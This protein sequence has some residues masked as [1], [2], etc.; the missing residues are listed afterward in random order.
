MSS[1]PKAIALPEDLPP[2]EP[3][4]KTPSTHQEQETPSALP[5]TASPE[6]S[7]ATSTP[8]KSSNGRLEA[9]E[10]PPKPNVRGCKGHPPETRELVKTLFMSGLPSTRIS[11]DTG[12]PKRTIQ[13]WAI[14][15]HWGTIRTAIQDRGMQYAK[16]VVEGSLSAVSKQVRADLAREVAD[17]V[18]VLRDKRPT[19]LADL[20]NTKYRTGR[21]TTVKTIA[22]TAS[23]VFGWESETKVGL[24]VPM[25]GL[26]APSQEAPADCGPDT[27]TGSVP[28]EIASAV[29]P[30]LA[31]VPANEGETGE[32]VGGL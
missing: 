11:A 31:E 32:A 19:K 12:I 18:A 8:S 14:A 7:P 29:T 30:Q 13:K 21:A 16:F 3:G 24:I 23:A 25:V 5:P 20:Q 1:I 9:I 28:I 15:G 17:Q 27:P 6:P 22:D 4:V 2:A 10:Q 26:Q